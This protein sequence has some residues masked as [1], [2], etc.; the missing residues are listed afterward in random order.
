MSLRVAGERE[1]VEVETVLYDWPA[2]IA[3]IRQQLRA[4]WDPVGGC[5]R[6]DEG[7]RLYYRG[8]KVLAKIGLT[9]ECEGSLGR[10]VSPLGAKVRSKTVVQIGTVMKFGGVWEL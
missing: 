3:A 6:G 9:K 5:G 10:K 4:G 2:W 8:G 7:T 1:N